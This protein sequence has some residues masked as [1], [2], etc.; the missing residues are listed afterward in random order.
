MRRFA[1][2]SLTYREVT[3]CVLRIANMS[4]TVD[5]ARNFVSFN[6]YLGG[7]ESRELVEALEHN[8]QPERNASGP[9]T[10]SELLWVRV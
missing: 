10:L 1:D 2:R 6:G 4:T 3:E 8:T 5:P 9:T 7:T